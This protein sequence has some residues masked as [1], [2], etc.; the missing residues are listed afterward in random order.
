MPDQIPVLTAA[1][2]EGHN[3]AARSIAAAITQESGGRF[4]G[5]V[6]DLFAEAAPATAA[7][8]GKAYMSVSTRFPALW[9]RIFNRSGKIRDLT[10]SRAI[11]MTGLPRVL[12]EFLER[13]KPRALVSTWPLYA[14]L[15]PGLENPALRP[16]LTATVVTDS[17]TIH[18]LWCQAVADVWFVTDEHSR[19]ILIQGGVPAEKVSATGFAVPPLFCTLEPRTVADANPPRVLYFATTKTVHARTTLESLLRS[20]PAE[21]ELTIVLGRH[22]ARLGALFRRMIAAHGRKVTVHGWTREVPQLLASHDLVITKAGGAT[23]HECLAAGIPAVINY[24]IPGQEEGNAQ[25]L[26][27]LGCGCLHDSADD[28]GQFIATL[29]SGPDWRR[30]KENML[31]HRRP[32]GAIR[33][34][35]HLLAA[36]DPSA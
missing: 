22:E 11:A 29:L 6:K 10:K 16:R 5:V 4:E 21:V 36:I 31:R 2:G 28:M 35:R 1:F 27:E 19:K 18:P 3:S 34:A 20:L 24:M 13:E 33:I 7:M 25:L 14:C 26:E 8:A 9:K 15:L 32:D 12:E 30:M 23:V 17:I